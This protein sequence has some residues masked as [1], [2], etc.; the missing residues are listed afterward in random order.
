MESARDKH[1]GE[2]IEAENL[3]M[4]DDVDTDGYECWEASQTLCIRLHGVLVA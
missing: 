2:I 3:W 4:L 1:T